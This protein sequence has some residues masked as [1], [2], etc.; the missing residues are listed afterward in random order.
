MQ[1]FN[2]AKMSREEV[3]EK[4]RGAMTHLKFGLAL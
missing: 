2:Y 1:N 4:L 3:K